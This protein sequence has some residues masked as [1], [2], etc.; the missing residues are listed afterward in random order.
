MG[1]WT[2]VSLS[3]RWLMSWLWLVTAMLTG[4]ESQRNDAAQEVSYSSWALLQSPG[5]VWYTNQFAC[6][7]LRAKLS[8]SPRPAKKSSGSPGFVMN[9]TW[10]FLYLWSTVTIKARWPSQRMMESVK[11]PS[12]SRF[13]TSSPRKLSRL[14]WL[15][16]SIWR[17]KICL[18]TFLL[19]LWLR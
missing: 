15:T 6:L 9:S 7:L 12:T 10:R 5:N 2:W 14:D 19:S 16:S 8:F 3:P 1:P 13:E 4:L 17:L 11:E 18:L